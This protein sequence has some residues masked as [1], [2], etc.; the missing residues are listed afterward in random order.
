[1]E[2]SLLQPAGTGDSCSLVETCTI[3]IELRQRITELE[4]NTSIDP[5]TGLWNRAHFDQIVEKELDRS[6]RY[7]QPLSL[8]LLDL[9]HFGRI[10]AEHGRPAGDAALR[11][12][13]R[14]TLA[15]TSVSDEY[16]RWSGDQFAVLTIG[17]GY[18]AAAR[19]AKNLREIVANHR[20]P[21]VGRITVSIGVAEHNSAEDTP[22][23][24]RRAE[25][26]LAAAK[27]KGRDRV[28]VDPQGSSDQWASN[29]SISALHLVWHEAYECG[30]PTI[31]GQHYK[32]FELANQLIEEFLASNDNF[33]RIAPAYA[34]LAEHIAQHFSDEEAI[35]SRS[36]Y[37]RLDAHRRAHAGLLGHATRLR[38]AVLTGDA[39]L[40]A[41]IEF[42]A[43]DVVAQ[44]LFKADRDF[45]PLFSRL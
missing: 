30:E 7:H 25:T 5:L 38:D 14:V 16:F 37:A 8:L 22:D 41:L 23:W 21:G 24:L 12:F 29:R 32:L 4:R 28:L 34:C 2:P 36:G 1:M 15:A 19:L 13:A 20:F 3:S 45:F 6:V 31:D 42:I 11:E 18:R 10:N 17:T 33:E 39:R 44:H 43:D 27:Q 35:L 40:G 9:D 26:M